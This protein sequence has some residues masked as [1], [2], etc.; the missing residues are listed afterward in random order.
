MPALEWYFISTNI[1]IYR[2][3]ICQNS[4]TVKWIQLDPAWNLMRTGWKEWNG[5]AY[6]SEDKWRL[7]LK[8]R[9]HLCSSSHAALPPCNLFLRRARTTSI[10][11]LELR[12]NFKSLLIW[13]THRLSPRNNRGCPS[14][15]SEIPSGSLSSSGCYLREV[16]RLMYIFIKIARRSVCFLISLYNRPR[17]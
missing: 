8:V 1:S 4:N 2:G 10:P 16:E 11:M 6:C 12:S 3:K 15:P 17:N 14:L 13:P 9:Y 7:V 5:V